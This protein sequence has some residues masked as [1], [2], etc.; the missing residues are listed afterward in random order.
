MQNQVVVAR[1][2]NS[3]P[4]CGWVQGWVVGYRDGKVRIKGEMIHISNT[5]SGRITCENVWSCITS[6]LIEK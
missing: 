2:A 1:I 3:R 6:T 4:G 5:T